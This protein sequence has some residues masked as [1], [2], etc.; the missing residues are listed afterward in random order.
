MPSEDMI[1][2]RDLCHIILPR[3]LLYNSYITG[4]NRCF[5]ILVRRRAVCQ[6]VATN[7]SSVVC[8]K[9]KLVGCSLVLLYAR[10]PARLHPNTTLSLVVCGGYEEPMGCRFRHAYTRQASTVLAS[11]VSSK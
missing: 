2:M 1:F 7:K 4:V 10:V 8:P 6:V 11:I 9:P 3:A 5:S